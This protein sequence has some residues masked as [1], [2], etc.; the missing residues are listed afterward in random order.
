MIDNGPKVGVA[1]IVVKDGKVLLGKRKSL[2]GNGTWSFPG[3]H[4]EFN[5][6]VEECAKREILEEAGINIENLKFAT[7]TNDLHI[8]E[9]K[10][11]ITL[12]LIG[13]YVSGEVRIMEPEKCEEWK[14]FSWNQLPKP[15]F[16][17]IE[18]LLKKGF[19]PFN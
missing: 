6:E 7:F 9:G 10:H 16:L 5:E 15:L 14:W 8:S 2:H 1:A 19:S 18:N 17:P 11:Y 4:L 3:G 13:D 12:F